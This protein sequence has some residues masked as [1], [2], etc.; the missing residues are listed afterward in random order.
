MHLI[1]LVVLYMVL[2]QT[3]GPNCQK[4]PEL[5]RICYSTC[6][7]MHRFPF[8]STTKYR[9]LSEAASPEVL[10]SQDVS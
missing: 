3:V 9:Y 8:I 10:D 7:V 1:L 6:L 5:L 4:K 2:I